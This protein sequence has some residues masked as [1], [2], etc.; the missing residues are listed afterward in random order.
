MLRGAWRLT[1]LL[2]LVV[3]AFLSQVATAGAT[4][5]PAP[6]PAQPP[7]RTNTE[8]YWNGD[9]GPGQY[10]VDGYL[11]NPGYP[12]DPLSGYPSGNPP[13]GF[14]ATQEYFAGIIHGQPT[15]GSAV[16]GLYCIDIRTDTYPGFGYGLGTWDGANVPNVGYVARI[17]N[18]Y[19]P[20]MPNLPAGLTDDQ[21]GA[22]VQAAIWFF[23]DG[24]VLDTSTGALRAAV[25]NIVNRVI[26]QGPLVEPPPPTLT[27]TP[28]QASGGA[29]SVLGPFT[30]TTD[31]PSATV[32]IS[33][34]TMYSD[35]AGT[36]PIRDG[37]TVPSGQKIWLRSSGPSTAVLEATSKATV[38]SGNVYLYDG[39]TAGYTA[40]Q[41]LILA[42][43]ATLTTTVQASA[44]FKPSGSLVVRKTIAGSAAGSQGRVVIRVTCDDG[45]RRFA[46]IL[47]AGTRRGTRSRTYANI[48]AGT[49]CT[50]I[51]TSN[52]SAVGT[53]VVVIGGGQEATIDTGHT[54]VVR[55]LD[56]YYHVGA[57]LERKTI[58]GPAAGT[59]GPI[60]IH[61]VCNG[62]V[63]TPDFTI[64]AGAPAGDQ[65]KQ[66]NDIRVPATCTVTETADGHTNT[67]AVDVEG[68]GQTVSIG[69]G[70][71]AEANIT[72]TYGLAPGQL[73]VVKSITGP[74]AGQQAAVVIHTVCDGAPLAPDF[75]IPAG[76]TGNQSQIYSNIPTPASCVVTETTNGS[77]SSVTATVSGSPTTV[78]I[79]AGGSGTAHFTDTYGAAPGSL[80]ITKNIAGPL[81]GHQGRV[82]IQVVCNGSIVAPDFV[83]PAG[84]P[85]G[86]VSQSFDNL[87]AGSVCTVTETADG[88]TNEVTAT[89]SGDDQTVTVPAGMVVPVSLTDVFL[90][91][92][93]FAGDGTGGFLKVTKTIAGPAAR[94][95]GPIVI[96]VACGGAPNNYV[97]RIPARIGAGS[98]S[99]TFSVPT[100]SRC[101][102][103]ETADGH[104]GTV[105]V[106]AS[107]S[108]KT[109]TIP[110]DATV[111]ARLTDIFTSTA[112]VTG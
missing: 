67:V 32:N 109:L 68:S 31:S 11:P 4:P 111:T 91:S 100:G 6:H 13:T 85:A 94:Q 7:V 16:V 12:F 71:I 52:G 112:P 49:K 34:G 92:P 90:R 29:G 44:E 33:G 9:L 83:I 87:P 54:T 61:T 78:M 75:V 1:V 15:D 106:V 37:A 3:G 38:P 81:A 14:T 105:A 8:I 72:D 23:S 24:F 59:Q 76:A 99:R 103:T 41:K 18:E 35:P 57:L 110:A 97:F 69:A 108:G 89:V 74:Q 42:E 88:E 64:P 47:R 30:V 26:A 55:I 20:N 62:R 77:T 65:T 56:F 102:V 86:T 25:V 48:P 43:S 82:T 50:V 98:V 96:L 22:A 21:R 53:Q 73:E 84:T 104:T 19:Y 70:E 51:E 27:L 107:G 66:Y 39:N 79:P 93:G 95:H 10:N 46:F 2:S 58:A 28:A 101:T 60:T 17:L 80:L 45:V 63:L 5:K 36:V 40:A